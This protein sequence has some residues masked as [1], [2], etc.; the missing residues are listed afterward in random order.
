MKETTIGL[1]RLGLIAMTRIV[2]GMGLGLLL[3]EKVAHR[4]RRTL[5]LALLGIGACSTM[6]LVLGVM[7]KSREVQPNGQSRFPARGEGL[8]AD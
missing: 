6:P 3:S 5:G 1:P 8:P 4:S 7:R 2:M